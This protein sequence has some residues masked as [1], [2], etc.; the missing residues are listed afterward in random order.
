[1]PSIE[2]FSIYGF[3]VAPSLLLFDTAD[4]DLLADALLVV[5]EDLLFV[6]SDLLFVVSDLL[7]LAIFPSS[8]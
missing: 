8:M 3:L 1:M 4:L 7:F 2:I 5:V 6:A